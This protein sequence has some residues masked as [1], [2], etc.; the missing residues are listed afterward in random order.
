MYSR[1]KDNIWAAGLTEVGS[2]SSFNNGDKYFLCVIVVFT[3]YTRVKLL[4]DKS[5]KRELDGFL[6]IV[7]E[8]KLKPDK[9]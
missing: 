8:S 9:L 1:F 4:I 3:K 7:Y 2:L 5:S 6:R